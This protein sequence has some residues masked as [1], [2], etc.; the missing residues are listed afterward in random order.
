MLKPAE[1]SVSW[2][3]HDLGVLMAALILFPS[4]ISLN[5]LMPGKRI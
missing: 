1:R 5:V 2:V 3:V 4:L